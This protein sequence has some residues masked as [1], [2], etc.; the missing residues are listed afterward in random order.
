MDWSLNFWTDFGPW[1]H[2][3]QFLKVLKLQEAQKHYISP[4]LM[5]TFA[6]IVYSS[7]YTSKMIR[8][9]CCLQWSPPFILHGRWPALAVA[10]ILVKM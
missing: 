4:V 3:P 10:F 1:P 5:L 2:L 9:F 8:G 6:Y 7:S